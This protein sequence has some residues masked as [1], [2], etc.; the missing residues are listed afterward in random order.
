MPQPST[1]PTSSQLRFESDAEPG[2]LA[3]CCQRWCSSSKAWCRVGCAA[4]A[5]AHGAAYSFVACV[6]LLDRQMG[7]FSPLFDIAMDKFVS[8]DDPSRPVA[9]THAACLLV[10]VHFM[11]AVPYLVVAAV[12]TRTAGLLI[13]T[14]AVCSLE[15]LAW[16][17]ALGFAMFTMETSVDKL[18]LIQWGVLAGA[19]ALLFACWSLILTAWRTRRRERELA[20]RTARLVSQQQHLQAVALSK[21]RSRRRKS[22]AARSTAPSTAELEAAIDQ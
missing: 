18:A 10:A 21:K 9:E 6:L 4:A 1:P 17:A 7:R 12:G 22:T 15:L 2:V 8:K 11:L 3:I 5:V 19:I 14:F 20:I 13:A 16:L